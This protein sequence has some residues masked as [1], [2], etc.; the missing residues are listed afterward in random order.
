VSVKEL[1]HPGQCFNTLI[2]LSRELWLMIDSVMSSCCSR[3]TTAVELATRYTTPD[4]IVEI[5]A[6]STAV[7]RVVN[8]L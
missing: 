5:G 4:A 6:T 3:M 1:S 2:P 7:E 8:S